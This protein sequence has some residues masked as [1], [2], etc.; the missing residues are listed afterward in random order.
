MTSFPRDPEPDT[1]PH[2]QPMTAPCD[3]CG[4][5]ALDLDA[6][7]TVA[8][9]RAAADDAAVAAKTARAQAARSAR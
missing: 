2:G 6:W 7:P 4:V 5:P 9:A 3:P 8:A 1:C